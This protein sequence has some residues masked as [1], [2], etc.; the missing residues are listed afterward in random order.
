MENPQES[1]APQQAPPAVAEPPKVEDAVE[2]GRF[3]RMFDWVADKAKAVGTA[4]A[5]AAQ[6]TAGLV[7]TGLSYAGYGIKVAYDHTLRP[8]LDWAEHWIPFF[9]EFRS[10]ARVYAVV[11]LILGAVIGALVAAEV[12]L[13]FFASLAM[14]AYGVV[15]I[16]YIVV[17]TPSLWLPILFDIWWVSGI[18]ITC[19][20]V[21]DW[22][23][24]VYGDQ[25]FWRSYA[26]RAWPGMY[27][28]LSQRYANWKDAEVVIPITGE[29]LEPA[30]A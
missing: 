29:V 17:T 30:S 7:V 25:G 8:V 28:F 1:P 23:F 10:C 3:G 9:G 6:Y 18:C 27:E 12:G 11:L 22:A 13:G 15:L 16:P 24:G 14:M 20:A 26:Y 21:I 4:I 19:Y 5:N 2:R